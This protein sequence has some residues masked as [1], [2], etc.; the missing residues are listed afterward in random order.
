[1]DCMILFFFL[2]FL[3][4]PFFRRHSSYAVWAVS[5]EW[6]YCDYLLA[7]AVKGVMNRA[8]VESS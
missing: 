2:A 8:S 5:C 7:T 6:T 3:S 1:M 4:V